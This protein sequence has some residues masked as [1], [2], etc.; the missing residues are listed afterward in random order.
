[1]DLDYLYVSLDLGVVELEIE[2]GFSYDDS[3]LF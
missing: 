3:N 2:M 1:M